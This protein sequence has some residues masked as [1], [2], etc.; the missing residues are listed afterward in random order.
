[1]PN[2]QTKPNQTEAAAAVEIEKQLK[3]V[4]EKMPHQVPLY[5][6]TQSGQNEALNEAARNMIRAFREVSGKIEFKE[7]DLSHQLAQKWDVSTSP[8]ILFDPEQY[9]IRYLGVPYGEEGRTF[10]GAI[11]LLG[12][13][14]SGMSEQSLK[15]LDK[16][17]YRR[18]VKVFVSA[19]CPFCPDQVLNAVKAALE[20][21]EMVSLEIIDIQCN[22]E[23]ADR[24]SAYSVPQTY[25]N[26]VLI[27]QG[28]QPEEL[29]LSSLEKLEPQTIF[30]PDNDAEQVET[31]VVI[32]GGGPSGLAAGIYAARSGLRTVVVERAALGGQVAI[33][34]IVENYPGFT[35]VPGKTLVD[36]TVS[37]ALEYVQIFQGEEVVEIQP[38]ETI[39][40]ITSRRRFLTRAVILATGANYARLGAP[41]EARLAGRG[42][43]YCATCDGMLFRG[44]KV[45]VVGGGNSAATEALHLYN[46]GV[47]VTMVHRRDAFRAQEY[48]VKSILANGIPVL[49]N[50]EI[51]EIKGQERVSEVLLA[52]NQ[53]G[54]TTTLPT[55]GVF[56]AVGYTPTV[57]LAKK[58]GIELTPEGFIK[59]DA[60]HRT[61]I[62]G[63]Y[64]AGDVEGGYKQIVTAMAQGSEAAMSVYEDLL[65]PY[66]QEK[67]TANPD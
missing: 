57:D 5:L 25:A 30:I 4:F 15:I 37:H 19:T 38:G 13:R 27:G 8:T 47:Q 60:H 16:I 2:H 67:G 65:H 44:K 58:T 33:T 42:V 48:L 28:A 22:P 66:W 24:Y 7:F 64:S 40:V 56:I 41:G 50:S 18:L 59:R 62:P 31:D 26:E 32:V 53:T 49:W 63:I 35:R 12:F 51:K 9:S 34:P 61:N 46:L 6:F 10:L 11:L 14:A 54:E 55:D 17:D 23:L 20:K 29:F 36:I 3:A 43:S 1:M 45:V 52:N 39:T 21:P